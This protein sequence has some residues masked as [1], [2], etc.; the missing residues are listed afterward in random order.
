MFVLLTAK[1]TPYTRREQLEEVALRKEERKRPEHLL[2][3]RSLFAD[4]TG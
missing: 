3:G 2:V 4:A 1:L